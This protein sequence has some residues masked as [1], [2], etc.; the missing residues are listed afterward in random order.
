MALEPEMALASF[1]LIQLRL[2]EIGEL[3][4]LF[5]GAHRI[6]QMVNHLVQEE[7]A[8]KNTNH[9]RI[10]TIWPRVRVPYVFRAS[11]LYFVVSAVL[12]RFLSE[13]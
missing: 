5:Q 2:L 4:P 11:S 13:L 6:D 7:M 8:V 3:C 1:R 10:G 12:L 9:W